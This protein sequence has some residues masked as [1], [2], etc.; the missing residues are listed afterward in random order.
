MESSTLNVAELSAS[1]KL[2][3]MERLWE[4]MASGDQ[5]PEPPAWHAEILSE[6]EVEWS[7]RHTVSQDWTEAKKEIRNE[8]P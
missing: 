4:S 2:A 3:L 1:E 8:L 5:L 7:K 6:R